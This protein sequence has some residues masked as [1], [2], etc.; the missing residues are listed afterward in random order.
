MR[1]EKTTTKLCVIYQILIYKGFEAEFHNDNDLTFPACI[2][3][4]VVPRK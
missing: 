3:R 4:K 2:E 1:K